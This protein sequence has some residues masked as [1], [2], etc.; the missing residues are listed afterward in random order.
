MTTIISLFVLFAFFLIESRLRQG[1]AAKSMEAGQFDRQS[2]RLL[3]IAYAVCML[4]LLLSFALNALSFA[5]LPPWL[6]WVGVAL[7]I[8][9]VLL[10]TWAN[11][12]LGAFYTRTLKVAEGQSIIREGPYKIIRHPGYLGM[13]LT[14]WGVSLSTAN[15]IVVLIV[16][17][18][19]FAVYSYRIENEEKM[20]VKEL[21]GY[22][23]YRSHTWRLIPFLY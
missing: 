4:V 1:N 9:G 3:G 14:W 13:I 19:I 5:V 17:I 21:N 12:I 23:E 10:R 18:T 16:A 20:L 11:R 2:T 6:G 15:W 8:A 7:A 22:A